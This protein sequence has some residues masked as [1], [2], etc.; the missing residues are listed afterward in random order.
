MV[1]GTLGHFRVFYNVN[2]E[3][4][5]S[6]HTYSIPGNNRKAAE[7]SAIGNKQAWR[8]KHTPCSPINPNAAR[9][10]SG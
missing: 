4:G 9:W 7:R 10:N 3:A 5:R 1:L 6:K 2:N 8:L